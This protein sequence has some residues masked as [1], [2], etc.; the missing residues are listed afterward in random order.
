MHEVSR[1]LVLTFSSEDVVL[2]RRYRGLEKRIAKEGER[3]GLKAKIAY[4][5]GAWEVEELFAK[6]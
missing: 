1:S 4:W 2:C 3:S 5:A 6:L